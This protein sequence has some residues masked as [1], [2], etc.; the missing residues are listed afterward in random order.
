MHTIV[1]K[2]RRCDVTRWWV[3][4][5]PSREPLLINGTVDA[6]FGEGESARERLRFM[7]AKPLASIRA[8]RSGLMEIR[9]N[10]D[11]VTSSWVS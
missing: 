1:N 9:L 3:P 8:E 11:L 2:S 6:S 4:E 5:Q 7:D 10:A